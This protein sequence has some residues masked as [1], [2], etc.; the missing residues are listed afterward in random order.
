[1]KSAI[2]RSY[3]DKN[4]RIVVKTIEE[5]QNNFS[6]TILYIYYYYTLKC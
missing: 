1:M 6:G 4:N 2:D 5:L 3:Y